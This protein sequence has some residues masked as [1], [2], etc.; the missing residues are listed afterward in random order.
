MASAWSTVRR[1]D[2]E[3]AASPAVSRLIALVFLTAVVVGAVTGAG[4]MAW[5]LIRRAMGG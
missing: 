2:D 4:W 5:T 1:H 3:R